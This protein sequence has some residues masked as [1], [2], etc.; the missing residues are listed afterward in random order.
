MLPGERTTGL[1][2]I[3]EGRSI[4]YECTATD[5]LDPPVATTVWMGTAFN[6]PSTVATGNNLITLQHNIFGSGGTT[7]ICG[8]LSAM[9]I[10]FNGNNYTYC[11]VEWTDGY[12]YFEWDNGSWK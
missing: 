7:G 2:C 11:W 1:G 3:P 5:P 9:S 6:C 4:S 12:L 10:R 8:G